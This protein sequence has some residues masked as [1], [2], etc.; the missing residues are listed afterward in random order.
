MTAN[1]TSPSAMS[2]TDTGVGTIA[3]YARSVLIRENTPKLVWL[4]AVFIAVVAR[5]AGAT[6]TA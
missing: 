1:S 4:R 3:S 6:N 2:V 5:M